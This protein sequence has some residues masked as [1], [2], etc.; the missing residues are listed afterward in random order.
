MRPAT[1]HGGPP[2]A[3]PARGGD[4]R[5]DSWPLMIDSNRPCSLN[6]SVVGRGI[7]ERAGFL[8]VLHELVHV[9]DIAG[10]HVQREHDAVL[11][12]ELGPD[13][14]DVCVVRQGRV[15][16]DSAGRSICE[17]AADR[18]ASFAWRAAADAVSIWRGS[19]LPRSLTTCCRTSTGALRRHRPDAPMRCRLCRYR[20]PVVTFR[21][22][23]AATMSATISSHR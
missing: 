15:P 23:A 16:A 7:L 8:Q 2:L 11:T 10:D 20:R 4:F 3:A 6:R 17:N 21:T 19:R 12:I 14:D 18:S 1:R 13:R 5:A 9:V 22:V